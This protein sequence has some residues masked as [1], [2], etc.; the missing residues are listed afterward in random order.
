MATWSGRGTA[1]RCSRTRRT[2]PAP[3]LPLAHTGDQL[4]AVIP[5]GREDLSLAAAFEIGRLLA[6]SQPSMVAALLE[7]RQRDYQVAR[8]HAIWDGI[9]ADLG[10]TGVVM[11]AA[12]S[13]GVMLSRAFAGAAASAPG[14]VIGPPREMRHPGR[15][16]G[17]QG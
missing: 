6:L 3:R 17:A 9:I 12:P 1:D 7:W 10:I 14:A 16:D 4:R 15:T 13:L 2:S 8:G 11:N 5:D